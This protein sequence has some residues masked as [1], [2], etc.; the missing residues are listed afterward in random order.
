MNSPCILACICILLRIGALRTIIFNVFTG[1][2]SIVFLFSFNLL[3]G[4]HCS[5]M[6]MDWARPGWT[7]YANNF[8]RES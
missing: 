4:L 3:T 2:K 5:N 1:A 6:I 7:G 8:P